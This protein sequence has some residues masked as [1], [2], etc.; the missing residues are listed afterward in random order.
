MKT[1][2]YHHLTMEDKEKCSHYRREHLLFD[3]YSGIIIALMRV[4]TPIPKKEAI[5]IQSMTEAG[6]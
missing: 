6:G 5:R 3:G 2:L 4:I 1:W